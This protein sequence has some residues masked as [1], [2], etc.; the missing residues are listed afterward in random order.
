M[1]AILQKTILQKVSI[2]ILSVILVCS[3]LPARAEASFEIPGSCQVQTDTGAAG[4]VKTLDYYYNHNTYFSLRDIAM[5]LRDT[6]KA[7][8]LEVTKNSVSLSP[9]NAYTPV[10]GENAPWEDS[11]NP[12]ISLRRN[13]FKVGEQTVLYYTMIVRL[14]SGYYDCFMMAADLAMILDMDIQ[15]HRTGCRL[16]TAPHTGFLL[17]LSGGLGT[18]RL[19]LRGQRRVGRRCLYGRALLPISVRHSLSHSQHFQAYDMSLGDGCHF[20]RTD[21]P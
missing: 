3:I 11:E 18:G 12:D 5:V 9:G 13:E 10:G 8:S 1:K 14:P 7:F 17:C 16:L 15:N 21:Y 20:I 2:L 6:D 19:F 4:T